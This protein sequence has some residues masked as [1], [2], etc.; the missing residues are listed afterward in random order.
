MIRFFLFLAGIVSL[1]DGDFES[2]SAFF[3]IVI[4][5]NWFISK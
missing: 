5:I 2:A 3:L 4:I 1:I